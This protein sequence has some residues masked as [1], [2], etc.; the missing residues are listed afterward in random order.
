MSSNLQLHHLDKNKIGKNNGENDASRLSPTSVKLNEKMTTVHFE[1]FRNPHLCQINSNSMGNGVKNG[2]KCHYLQSAHMG[3][4]HTVLL[5]IASP[6][7]SCHF[8][9]I[10]NKVIYICNKDAT[11]FKDFSGVELFC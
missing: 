3:E 2:Y 1:V 10:F 4:L 7:R 11:T 6:K 5:P 8:L 9:Y